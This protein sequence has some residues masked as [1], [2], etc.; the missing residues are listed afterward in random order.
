[1]FLFRKGKRCFTLIELLVVIA[2]IAVLIGLLLPAVQ[3]V[4]EAA[5]RMKCSAQLKQLNLA[6]HGY[7]SANGDKLPPAQQNLPGAS[8]YCVILGTLLPHL[9]QEALFKCGANP[10]AANPG[11]WDMPVPIGAGPP[12]TNPVR[13]QPIKVYQCPSDPTITGGWSA[14]QVGGWMG[15]SYAG[16]WTL[17]GGNSTSAWG[18]TSPTCTLANIPDGSS[19]TIAFVEKA[20]ACYGPSGNWGNLWSYP[21]ASNWGPFYGFAY[22]NY[23][24]PPQIQPLPWN[25]NCDASRSSTF[26]SSAAQTAMMDGSVRGVTAA[27]S[28]TTWWIA[29][30][31]DDGL[32]LPSDW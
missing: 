13:V 28:P 26:H 9:E 8:Q 4:R 31:P 30:R 6:V 17:F 3:K 20:S 2:I 22:G 21:D 12:G 32:V 10:N 11:F 5:A 1:M 24:L 19:N 16:N 15:S 14:V 23:Q 27:V 7:A 18:G 25:G 29:V